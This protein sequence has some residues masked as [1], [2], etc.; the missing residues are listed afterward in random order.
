[1]SREIVRFFGFLILILVLSISTPL[2]GQ[3]SGNIQATATVLPALT[4]TGMNNLR[5][6]VVIPG[7]DK[8]VD[9]ATVGFAGAFQLQGHNSAEVSLD[10]ALPP[11]LLLDST[12]TMPV[13]FS[14]TDASYDDGTGGGQGAPAGNIDPNGPFTL[15]L[16]VTGLLDIWLGGS[17][18][19][20]ITQTGGDYAADVTLTA[21]YTGN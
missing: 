12:A 18:H 7:V 6:E 20:T 21:I 14:N 19:P 8:S 3:E 17:V 16:G 5:F 11:S 15:R 1:M 9:K 4:V 2:R 13:D 10:F